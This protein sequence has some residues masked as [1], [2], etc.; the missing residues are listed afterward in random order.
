MWCCL[1]SVAGAE[2]KSLGSSGVT[3]LVVASE[4]DPVDIPVVS[5]RVTVVKVQVR[6]GEEASGPMGSVKSLA[7]CTGPLPSSAYCSGSGR[8]FKLMPV[9][10][11]CCTWLRYTCLHVKPVNI[12]T[13]CVHVCAHVCVC[14]C[15]FVC[16]IQ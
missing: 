3:H 11:R 4:L 1:L 6:S 8:V 5:S 9:L 2:V 12:P 7:V 13:V 14:V 15:A 16:V 10:M